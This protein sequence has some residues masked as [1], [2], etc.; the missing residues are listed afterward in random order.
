MKYKFLSLG[1]ICKGIVSLI[2][3]TKTHTHEKL[4]DIPSTNICPE[5][6]M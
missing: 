6:V 1:T 5:S 2:V 3:Q 4:Q